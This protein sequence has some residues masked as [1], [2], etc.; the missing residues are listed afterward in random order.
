MFNNFCQRSATWISPEREKILPDSTITN[1]SAL[2][3]HEKLQKPYM[4]FEMS[5]TLNK[6]EIHTDFIFVKICS[7]SPTCILDS[8]CGDFIFLNLKPRLKVFPALVCISRNQTVQLLTLIS[9]LFH[10]WAS[11]M[12]VKSKLCFVAATDGADTLG[13]EVLRTGFNTFSCNFRKLQH[14]LFVIT[15]FRAG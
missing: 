12:A 5:V 14:E 11:S 3:P 9:F 2:Y 6:V 13:K 4:K 1:P 10:H 8:E 15:D 7:I